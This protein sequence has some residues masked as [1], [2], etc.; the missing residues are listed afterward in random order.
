MHLQS[1]A[2]S[3]GARGLSIRRNW[4]S[5]ASSTRKVWRSPKSSSECLTRPRAR[6][7]PPIRRLTQLQTGW[8]QGRTAI[9]TAI[10][11]TVGLTQTLS[12]KD[13]SKSAR[14]ARSPPPGTMLGDDGQW[15]VE[16]S[17]A[18]SASP[19]K[20]ARESDDKEPSD[21]DTHLAKRE[22]VE[23]DESEEEEEDE[24]DEEEEEE[25]EEEQKRRKRKS[26][27]RATMVECVMCATRHL[28]LRPQNLVTFPLPRVTTRLWIFSNVCVDASK[29]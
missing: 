28:K 21:E 10:C 12:Q 15:I 20:R 11:T 1:Q 24:E 14:V 3:K 25:E 7:L 6:T 19:A 29:C 23:K 9:C 27:K 18:G 8:I 26:K 22:E 5:P 17:S 4:M 13:V 16:L 2:A